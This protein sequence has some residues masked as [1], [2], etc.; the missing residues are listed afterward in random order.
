MKFLKFSWLF[1]YCFIIFVSA[2]I[3]FAGFHNM[4]LA[5]NFKGMTDCNAFN[6]QTMDERYA[7]GFLGA[8]IGFFL[9]FLDSFLLYF[10]INEK[11]L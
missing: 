6:C 11:W 3:F 10:M 2:W 9:M 5:Y 7:N 4:D 1:L 8:T